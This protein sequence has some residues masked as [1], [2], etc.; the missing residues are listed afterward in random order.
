[1]LCMAGPLAQKNSRRGGQPRI[2][3]GV[4]DFDDASTSAIRFFRSRKIA[5]AYLNFVR[6]WVS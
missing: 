2:Y 1:M 6:E 3:G 4:L 5:M